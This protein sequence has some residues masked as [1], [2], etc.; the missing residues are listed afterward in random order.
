MHVMKF[1]IIYPPKKSENYFERIRAVEKRV[2]EMGSIVINP[3]P[4]DVETTN[5]AYDNV[6]HFRAHAHK[7][8]LSDAVLAMDGYAKEELGNKAMAEAMV[9]KK[10]IFWE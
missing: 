10:I 7:I 1:Y 9:L 3:L 8:N 4:E 5:P 6:D 2:A